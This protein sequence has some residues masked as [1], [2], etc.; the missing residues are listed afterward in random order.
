[1]ALNDIAI[2]YSVD[3]ISKMGVSIAKSGLFGIQNPDQAVALMLVAQAEN[4]HPASVANDYNI[5][6]GR[7]SLKADAMLAR[8]Q[9]SG[10]RV[11]WKELTDKRVVAVFSHPAGGSVE[12]SWD[13]ARAKKA[14]VFQA[15][16]SKGATGMWVKYP[17]QMLRARVIS[18]GIR[19]VFPGVICG[20]YTPEE[21]EDFEQPKNITPAEPI[22]VTA[23]QVAP[24]LAKKP[25]Q[26][27]LEAPG[28]VDYTVC[29][30]GKNAGEKWTDISIPEL[31]AY[32]K[33]MKP[34]SPRLQHVVAARKQK[35]TEQSWDEEKG[36]RDEDDHKKFAESASADLAKDPLKMS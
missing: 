12:I 26:P 19:T 22:T 35:E 17:R 18:E 32:E 1:M 10:G 24:S 5:I 14:E 25:E 4:R 13:I 33:A 21:A 11:E 29:H 23:E 31:I 30:K 9:E 36:Q 20:R 15:K 7:P 3:E 28:I 2:R 8:F 27:A 6:Q 34:G 16:T